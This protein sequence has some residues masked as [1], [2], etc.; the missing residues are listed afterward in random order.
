MRIEGMRSAMETSSTRRFP[1]NWLWLCPLLGITVAT[2]ILVAFGLSFWTS[3]L[4]ALLLV[5][6]ALMIW[7]GFSLR[8]SIGGR[9]HGK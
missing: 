4:V 3:L 8:H 9:P 6:P 1:S 7:G 2:W 5:C